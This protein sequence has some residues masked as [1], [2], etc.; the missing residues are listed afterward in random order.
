MFLFSKC[1]QVLYWSKQNTK[2]IFRKSFCSHE[3][4]RSR[5]TE[6][7]NL[8]RLQESGGLLQLFS[9]V[10]VHAVSACGWRL[11]AVAGNLIS[12]R[13]VQSLRS[14]STVH[15]KSPHRN[16]SDLEHDALW[17]SNRKISSSIP[18]HTTERARNHPSILCMVHGPA[19]LLA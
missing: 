4:R 11:S 8:R 19:Y 15:R 3:E 9:R 14:T 16:I 6:R 7:T 12:T 18:R 17:R 1:K 10:H 2:R 5:I 13:Q